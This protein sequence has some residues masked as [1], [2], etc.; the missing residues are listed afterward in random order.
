MLEEAVFDKADVQLAPGDKLVLYSD[1]L[2]ETE[3]AQGEFF[4][5]RRLQAFLLE[6]LTHS[7]AEL[8]SSLLASLDR[9][10]EG[11]VVRD[12]VTLLVLEYAP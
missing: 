8:H 1:G 7:A 5:T 2:T 9:F 4:D 6:H 3:N 11:G 12:D 10:S